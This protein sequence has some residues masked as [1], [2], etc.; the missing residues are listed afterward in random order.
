MH[1]AVISEIVRGKRLQAYPDYWLAVADIHEIGY[2][3]SRLLLRGN[4]VIIES[5]C[6]SGERAEG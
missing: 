1:Q 5:T 3:F 2:Q 6:K 4:P